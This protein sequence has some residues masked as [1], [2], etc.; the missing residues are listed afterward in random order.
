MEHPGADFRPCLE[1]GR[2]EDREAE[3]EQRRSAGRCRAYEAEGNLCGRGERK[4]QLHPDRRSREAPA[5][6][7]RRYRTEKIV[8]TAP[9]RRVPHED[10]IQSEHADAEIRGN[11]PVSD[12]RNRDFQPRR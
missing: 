4:H 5:S 10:W 7:W 2:L 11:G 8:R 12:Q 1:N 6:E 9:Q 3:R